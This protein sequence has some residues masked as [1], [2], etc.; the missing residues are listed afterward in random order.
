MEEAI[1]VL[2]HLLKDGLIKDYAIGGGI[3]TIFYI[4]PILTYDLDIFYIPKREEKGVVTLTPL[5]KFLK[6]RGY[7]TIKEHVE[8]GGIPVQ[9]IP[10]YNELIRDA[11]KNAIEIKYINSKTKIVKVEYLIA[12]M[13]QTNRPKDRERLVRILDEADIDEKMLKRILRKYSL[14]DKFER[15]LK[16]HNEG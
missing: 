11:V 16:R 13:L 7:K 12:I 10:V 3:A 9:F 14:L 15:I 4:E 5:Y 2:N 8:I 1:E 6:K